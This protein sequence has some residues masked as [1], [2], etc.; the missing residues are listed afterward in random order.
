L[1]VG[2]E[3]VED[4]LGLLASKLVVQRRSGFCLFDR[5]RRLQVADRGDDAAAVTWPTL[6][7]NAPDTSSSMR[8][9][10]QVADAPVSISASALAPQKW[11]R[12]ATS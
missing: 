12:P 5:H 1:A 2:H 8:A 3:Q 9:G 10:S 11:Q 6:R 7:L 4:C